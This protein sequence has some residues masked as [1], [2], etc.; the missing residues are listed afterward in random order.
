[1]LEQ[2]IN[3]FLVSASVAVITLIVTR[4]FLFKVI[5]DTFEHGT[6][7]RKL[8]TCPL[9][10]S[11]WC[12]LFFSL[13]VPIIDLPNVMRFFDY[14]IQ[15]LSVVALAAPMMNIIFNAIGGLNIEES[16]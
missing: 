1:M 16:E 4:S 3:L 11:T 7:A 13:F 5:R 6:Y 8:V 12:S 10:F 15:W 14:T 2:M 9:C